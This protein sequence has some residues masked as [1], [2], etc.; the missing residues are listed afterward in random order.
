[1]SSVV[2]FINGNGGSTLS[3]L[4]LRFF[5]E[6]LTGGAAFV[7]MSVLAM[8]GMVVVVSLLL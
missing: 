2:S 8:I 6:G 1:M 4:S 5:A 7:M 3:L